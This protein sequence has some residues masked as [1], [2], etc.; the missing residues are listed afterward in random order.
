MFFLLQVNAS[1]GGQSHEINAAKQ[2]R[3]KS[4][5]KPINTQSGIIDPP[6]KIRDTRC[7]RCF[8][9]QAA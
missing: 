9:L 7:L 5:L 1:T 2:E 8:V 3:E 4:G 6:Q